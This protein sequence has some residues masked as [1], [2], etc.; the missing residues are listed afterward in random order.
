MSISS[1]IKQYSEGILNYL[2]N[3]T[4]Y[5]K[6]KVVYIKEHSNEEYEVKL[7]ILNVDTNYIKTYEDKLVSDFK[8]LY[9]NIDDTKSVDIKFNILS[10]EVNMIFELNPS[11]KSLGLK[12]RYDVTIANTGYT[13]RLAKHGFG[14]YIPEDQFEEDLEDRN[15]QYDDVLFVYDTIYGEGIY[16]FKYGL[17]NPA[18]LVTEEEL[19]S[20]YPNGEL[21]KKLFN[22]I[23]KEKLDGVLVIKQDP[24]VLTDIIE[25]G[26]LTYFVNYGGYNNTMKQVKTTINGIDTS[27]NILNFDG[28]SG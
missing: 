13:G 2:S 3:T 14:K 8:L 9:T 19:Y 4:K 25:G 1:T 26:G 24:E 17:Y 27:I 23:K 7:I 22:I 11:R 20:S 6:G 18:T 15:I 16:L 28:E 21:N 5:I 12:E 10:D